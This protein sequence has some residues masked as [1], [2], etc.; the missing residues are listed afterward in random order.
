MRRVYFLLAI[1]LFALPSARAKTDRVTIVI[2]LDGY[3][4][5][6]PQWYDTPFFDEMA[7]CGVE[8]SL[9]PSFPSK[10]FLFVLAVRQI[11]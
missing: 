3:R 2:S 5:D 4:W 10:T 11:L 7:S 6:Y 1:L 9:I 8:A